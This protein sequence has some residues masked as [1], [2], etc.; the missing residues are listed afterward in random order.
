MGEKP[1]GERKRLFVYLTGFI[2]LVFTLPACTDIETRYHTQKRIQSFLET[3]GELDLAIARNLM[4]KG[5]FQASLKKNEEVLEKYHNF[6]GD[7]AL[8]QIGVIY[9][10]PNNRNHDFQKAE[11][12][13]HAIIKEHPNSQL[14]PEVETWIFILQTIQKNKYELGEMIQKYDIETA[15]LNQKITSMESGNKEKDKKMRNLKRNVET[16]Q[17]EVDKLKA[18]VVKLASQIE[19]I[20]NVDIRIEEKKR[21]AVNEENV[22]QGE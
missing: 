19:R 15:G 1:T 6:L 7:H 2:I 22:G 21:K 9:A 12:R 17:A 11:A 3:E 20:K 18:Q 8:F 4:A 14:K 5:Y 10:H 16:L 13:F